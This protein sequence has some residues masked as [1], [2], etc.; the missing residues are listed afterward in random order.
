MSSFAERRIT[1]VSLLAGGVI[2][3][4]GVVFVADGF[5]ARGGTAL[6]APDSP[7]VFPADGK[8]FR[9]LSAYNLF[10]DPKGQAPSAGVVPYDLNTPLFSDYTTKYRFVYMPEGKAAAYHPE[11]MFDYPVGT[12]LVKTFAYLHDIRDPSKGRD[13]IETRL[14]LHEEDGWSAWAYVWNDDETEATLKISGARQELSWIHYDGEERT[15]NYIIPNVNQCKGCHVKD[16]EFLPIG[17]KAWNL[18]KDY[19]Y[20][21]GTENQLAHWGEIGYLEDAPSPSEAPAVPAWDDPEAGTVAERARAYLDVNCAHC[22][23]PAGPASTSGLDLRWTQENP[24]DW[25]VNRAPVAAGRGSG[26]L[27]YDIVPGKPDESILVY[28]LKSTDPGVMMPELPRLTVH[29]EAVALIE[30]W[31]RDMDAS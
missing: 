24:Y 5:F 12:I 22:H 14:L 8:P 31:I 13:L 30:E 23:N 1:W 10:R 11:E 20:P 29:D 18:N 4:L 7:V 28:R 19:E 3:F 6:A 27:L 21:H 9:T 16:D 25:G 2:A 26:G 17:P 15:I